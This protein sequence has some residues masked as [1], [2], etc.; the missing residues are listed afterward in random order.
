ME[1]RDVLKRIGALSATGA[2]AGCL[3]VQ[4]QGEGDGTDSSSDDASGDGTADDGSS[5]DTST[6][7]ESGPAGSATVWYSLPDTETQAREQAIESFNSNSRHTIDGGDISDLRKKTTSAIPAGQGPASFDWAHDWVGDY[8][9]RGFLVDQSD[10]LSVGM[11]QFT[12]AAAGAVQFEDQV[13]GLPYAAE[14]VALVYNEE[15]VDEPPSS[16]SEM[17]SVMDEH[18]DPS[19]GTYGLSYPFDPYFTSAWVQSQGGY[20]FDPEQDPM[21]GLT[22]DATVQGLQFALDNF[23]PYMPNDPQYEAQAAAFADGNAAFAING[24]WYLATLNEKGVDFG[25]AKLP[26]VDGGEPNPYTGIQMWYFSTGMEDDA[27]AAAARSFIEWHVTNEDLVL[28]AAEEQ[29]AI[30]VLSEL[31]GS[32]EL[33]SN[34]KAF[35]EAVQQGVPM[36]THPKMNAVW[37]PYTSALIKAFNGDTDAAGAMEEAASTIRSNWE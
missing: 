29:G 14:T 11:D 15:Y 22:N 13:L 1:R 9:Q 25:T 23:K 26:S 35:S 18:H 21:L 36:P 28:Q 16:V 27:T 2:V 33:P 6:G 19:N 32:D 31:A 12:E 30:P 37:E 3:G 4:E 20:I 24:P 17:V 34:V 10:Q 8:A 7:T 5:G